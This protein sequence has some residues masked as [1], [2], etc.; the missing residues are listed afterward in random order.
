[1]L[2]SEKQIVHVMVFGSSEADKRSKSKLVY[3]ILNKV[4]RT[5]RLGQY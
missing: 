5:V 4:V 3:N 1:V 2:C